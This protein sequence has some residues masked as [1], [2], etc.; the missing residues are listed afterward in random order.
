MSS[1]RFGAVPVAAALAAFVGANAF[2]G[3]GVADAKPSKTPTY[4]LVNAGAFGVSPASP[5]TVAASCTT[6]R[7]VAARFCT[8]PPPVAPA[9]PG[10]RP[11]T[12]LVAMTASR[13]INRAPYTCATLPAASRRAR[14][15]PTSGSR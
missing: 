6:R 2:V 3:V 1:K 10:P 12:P 15:R 9:G 7:R 14:S 5:R 4:S 11:S 8:S 13:P